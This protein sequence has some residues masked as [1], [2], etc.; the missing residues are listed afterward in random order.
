MKIFLCFTLFLGLSVLVAGQIVKEKSINQNIAA[1]QTLSEEDTIREV[2]F[3]RIID[4]WLVGEPIRPRRFYLS[5]DDGKNPSVGL[6]KK[7]SDINATLKKVTES[8]ISHPEGSIVLDKKTKKQGDRFSVSKLKW[9][10]KD[11]VKLSAGSYSGNMGSDSCEF[12]LRKDNGNWKII[13][14]EKCVIS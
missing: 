11:E 3:R 10:T 7:L 2:V 8:Y 14:E 4:P 1:A 12:T 9:I 13:S 6:L 5:I